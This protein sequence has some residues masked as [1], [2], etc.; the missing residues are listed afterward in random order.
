VPVRPPACPPGGLATLRRALFR[1]LATLYPA[2]VEGVGS[3]LELL[4]GIETHVHPVDV[5]R[6]D[7]EV[8]DGRAVRFTLRTARA[9]AP[10]GRGNA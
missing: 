5:D 8:A 2:F 10:H 4:G 1:T 6:Q 7:P 3:G 9:R